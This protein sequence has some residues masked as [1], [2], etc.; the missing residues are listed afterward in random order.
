MQQR[1]ERGEASEENID[2]LMEA[3]AE[4]ITEAEREAAETHDDRTAKASG[5]QEAHNARVAKADR[6]A[7]A[8]RRA[9]IFLQTMGD[10]VEGQPRR[11]T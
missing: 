1:Q 8:R 2:K 5:T 4:A 7:E 3:I 11:T 9:S 6:E 10:S